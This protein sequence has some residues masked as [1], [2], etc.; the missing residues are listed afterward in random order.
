[1]QS[2]IMKKFFLTIIFFFIMVS[3]KADCISDL[4]FKITN[5]LNLKTFS[6][7][8]II[9]NKSNTAIV[10]W[11]I[12]IFNN[13]NEKMQSIEGKLIEPFNLDYFTLSKGSL[14]TE[15]ISYYKINCFHWNNEIKKSELKDRSKFEITGVP[16]ITLYRPKGLK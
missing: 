2:S 15:L 12:E 13:K 4:D 8:L 9:T 16:E 1:M 10:I 3:S 11:E 5:Q 6:D 14:A 7:R